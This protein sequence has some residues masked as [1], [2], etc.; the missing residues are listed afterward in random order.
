MKYVDEYRD[1]K[2]CC[3]LAGLINNEAIAGSYKIMEVCGTHTAA[4]HKFGLRSLL[5]ENIELISGPGCPVCVT[6]DGYLRNAIALSKNKRVVLATYS[7][8]LRVPVD[9]TSLEHERALGADIRGV[10]SALEALEFARRFPK[11]EIVFLGV[12]FETTAPGTAI[13]LKIAKEEGL[14]NFTVYSAHKTIPEALIALGQGQGLAIQGFL[15]PGHVSAII[16]LVGYRSVAKKLR[17]PCV[18]SGFEPV[19]ILF[20]IH[21][22]VKA[23]NQKKPILENEYERIVA[24]QGNK[25]AQAVLDEVFQRKDGF[26]RGLGCIPKTELA[27]RRAFRKF[28]AVEKFG[29]KK[30]TAADTQITTCLCADVLKGKIAPVRCPHFSKSCTPQAPKGPCMVSREGT[31]RSYFEYHG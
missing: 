2:K 31:C 19:D 26:W 16:G 15:L 6:S 30:E 18:I 1:V 10:N 3:K 17:L 27:L 23:I 9:N 11:N 4:I 5:S 24:S 29:L 21:R 14:R 28:D 7:D 13:A 12:G 20:S 25:R 8:M 22:I